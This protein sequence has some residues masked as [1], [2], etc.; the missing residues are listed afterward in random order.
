MFLREGAGI[1][2]SGWGTVLE[3]CF[4]E[5]SNGGKCLEEVSNGYSAMTM[6]VPDLFEGGYSS[7]M[8]HYIRNQKKRAVQLKFPND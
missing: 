2:R 4:A 3:P 6:K 1:E 7:Y 8:L 5:G